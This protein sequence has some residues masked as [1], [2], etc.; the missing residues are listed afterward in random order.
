MSLVYTV[1]NAAHLVVDLVIPDSRT[2]QVVLMAVMLAIG[3]LINREA[4]LWCRD[5]QGPMEQTL[6]IGQPEMGA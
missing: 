3:L 6:P 5:R 4:L 1:T 2:D